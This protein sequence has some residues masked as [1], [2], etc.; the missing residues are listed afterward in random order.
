M[1]LTQTELA[2]WVAAISTSTAAIVALGLAAWEIRRAGTDRRDRQVAQARLVTIEVEYPRDNEGV[3]V[4]C[5][6]VIVITNHS[7]QL[8]HRPR[9]VRMTRRAARSPRIGPWQPANWGQ[10]ADSSYCP[11]AML[12][13]HAQHRVPFNYSY[14]GDLGMIHETMGAES[15]TIAF[16]D[17]AGLRW[18]RTGNNEPI[19]V[20]HE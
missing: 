9:I 13:A 17:A 4:P 6:A 3:P 16:M 19:R 11:M 12:P 14:T 20:Y 15:V 18:Q 5:R 7:D 1:S 8:I 2:S 10:D